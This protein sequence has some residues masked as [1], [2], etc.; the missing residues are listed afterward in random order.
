MLTSLDRKLNIEISPSPAG[1]ILQP[2]DFSIVNMPA[3]EVDADVL[4][5]S[6]ASLQVENHIALVT[7]RHKDLDTLKALANLK[8]LQTEGGLVFTDSICL[9]YQGTTRRNGARL[10]V[11]SEPAFLFSKGRPPLYSSTKWFNP[12]FANSTNL[13][14]LTLQ[15]EKTLP[16]AA[17]KEKIKEPG[18]KTKWGNFSF[19]IASLMI[20]LSLPR[21]T[22]TFLYEGNPND[23]SLLSFI[24][25]Y[26]TKVFVYCSSEADARDAICRYEAGDFSH[27]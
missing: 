12:L 16:M 11:I 5:R 10:A 21:Q 20:G 15:N 6:Y 27:E 25:H 17:N 23:P 18:N 9:A 7:A 2:G 24:K 14:D 1:Y 22:N 19:D 3:N 4:A 26:D 13:W 8:K